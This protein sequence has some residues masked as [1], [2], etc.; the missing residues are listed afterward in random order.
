MNAR[1]EERMLTVIDAPIVSEKSTLLG[2]K[3]RTAVFRIS[4]RATKAQVRR[5]V[6][7]IFE[8]KVKKV[9]IVNMKGKK[10]RVRR[11]VGQRAAWKKAY[12]VMQEGYDIN[13]AELQ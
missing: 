9:G 11:H 5:A 8:V 4:P 3:R 1:D 10:V 7:R 12:V 13:L 2:D 6:E